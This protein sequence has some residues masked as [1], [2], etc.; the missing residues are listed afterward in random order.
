MKSFVAMFA[1]YLEFEWKIQRLSAA[2]YTLC[3]EVCQWWERDF[4][5]ASEAITPTG[6]RDNTRSCISSA[7]LNSLSLTHV[8]KKFWTRVFG[9]SIYYLIAITET[10]YNVFIHLLPTQHYSVFEKKKALCRI[11]TN[12]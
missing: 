1:A 11:S 2:A 3:V 10:P 12:S 7:G 9:L 4:G 5:R 8:P 6:G